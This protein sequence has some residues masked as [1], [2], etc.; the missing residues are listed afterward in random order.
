[1]YWEVGQ[2]K[3]QENDKASGIQKSP[4]H[5]TVKEN[6]T[7]GRGTGKGADQNGNN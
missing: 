1:M 5:K 2:I 6:I 7:S 3:P 4:L